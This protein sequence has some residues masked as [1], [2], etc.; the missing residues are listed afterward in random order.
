MFD[1]AAV[2][3]TQVR[4]LR[5]FI[6]IKIKVEIKYKVKNIDRYSLFTIAVRPIFAI[7]TLL[8]RN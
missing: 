7:V 2:P 8:A 6:Q 1:P 3:R 4:Y 5:Y